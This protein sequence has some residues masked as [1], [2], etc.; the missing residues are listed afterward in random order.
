MLKLVHELPDRVNKETFAE[1]LGIRQEHL[2]RA[3]C[4]GDVPEPDLRLNRRTFI[5]LR[6]TIEHWLRDKQR[7]TFA[8]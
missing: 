3:V 2:G 4:H 6:S 5:W 1:F 8:A 7:E